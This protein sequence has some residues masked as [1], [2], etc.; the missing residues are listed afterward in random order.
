MHAAHRPVARLFERF[1]VL[2]VLVGLGMLAMFGT[3]CATSA[4]K[5]A[6]FAKEPRTTTVADAL[7]NVGGTNW[8]TLTD[9]RW[10]CERAVTS[11]E[12]DGKVRYTY[13]PASDSDGRFVLIALSGQ[14][15][16]AAL[17]AKPVTGVL[18]TINPRFKGSLAEDEHVD[19]S[20][21]GDHQ[22]STFLG[23]SDSRTG[24]WIAGLLALL[25]G[26]VIWHYGRAMLRGGR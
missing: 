5:V 14:V 8:V 3:L 11:H 25:G 22:L 6:H 20:A 16:C 1:P 2:G 10:S 12:D 17:A 21:W 19:V 18:D 26:L 4:W 15:D 24:I 9:A 7:A 23:P 13:V